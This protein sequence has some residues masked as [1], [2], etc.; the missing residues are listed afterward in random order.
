ME[1]AVGTTFKVD[2][3]KIIVRETDTES[4][5]Y[6]DGTKCYFYEACFKALPQKSD[7]GWCLAGFREDE[8]N[9]IFLKI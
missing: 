5:I 9:V 6:K 2:K 8:K 4:C 1:R 3:D 7:A